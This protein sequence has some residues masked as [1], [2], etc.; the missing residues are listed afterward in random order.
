MGKWNSTE[1][2]F[3]KSEVVCK[4]LYTHTTQHNLPI[5]AL[6]PAEVSACDALYQV[7]HAGASKQVHQH[8][9]HELVVG[10]QTQVDP[11]R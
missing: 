10:H 1:R 7:F 9:V 5:H 8:I 2:K 3:P 6:Q 4:T 11:G